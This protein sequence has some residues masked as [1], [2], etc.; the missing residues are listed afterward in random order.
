MTNEQDYI[1]LKIS[2][3][4]FFSEEDRQQLSQLMMGFWGCEGIQEYALEE[5]ELDSLLGSKA[6]TGGPLPHEVLSEVEDFCGNSREQVVIYYF[7]GDESLERAQYAQTKTKELFPLLENVEIQSMVSHDWLTKWK[8]YYKPVIIDSNFYVYP[9]WTPIEEM[10]ASKYLL[11]EPGQAFGTGSHES[12]KLCLKQFHHY[13]EQ[14]NGSEP[15]NV[16]DFGCGSGILGMS[17]YLVNKKNSVIFYD[18][19]GA[20][21]DNVK[22]NLSL[23]NFD[24]LMF[25]FAPAISQLV[26]PFKE[27]AYKLVFANILL[28]ILI[29]HHVILSSLVAPKGYMIISGIMDDQWPELSSVLQVGTVFKEVN[30]FHENH[31]VSV[32]IQKM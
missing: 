10:K 15:M 16:I 24:A 29:E 4:T 26:S 28:P 3:P 8:E 12:T 19:D 14:I 6:V 20:A 27:T 9:S 32:L 5:K 18:I 11:I 31:W 21:Y 13:R 30:I 25:D 2:F 23:N 17:T 7:S 1:E 22:I